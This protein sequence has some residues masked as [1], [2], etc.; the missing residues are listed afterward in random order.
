MPKK[1]WKW[2]Q[3]WF[4]ALPKEEQ[5]ELLGMWSGFRTSPRFAR[6][7]YLNIDLDDNARADALLRVADWGDCPKWALEFL[8]RELEAHKHEEWANWICEAINRM[9]PSDRHY[10]PPERMAALY[11]DQNAHPAVRAEA[12]YSLGSDFDWSERDDVE[13]FRALC[14]DALSKTDD[15]YVQHCAIE[16]AVKLGGY[17]D[18]LRA[19]RDT[20]PDAKGFS[21]ASLLDGYLFEDELV[22]ILRSG[23]AP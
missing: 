8:W 12:V 4:R 11:Y 19:M 5:A 1:G 21:F 7:I 16:L 10:Y 6:W 3:E 9:F 2:R 13:P 22:S 20:V 17:E 14:D 18:R 23:Q 15:P